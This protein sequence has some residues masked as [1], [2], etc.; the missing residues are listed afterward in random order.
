VKYQWAVA[1]YK[2]RKYGEA[3]EL[4]RGVVKSDPQKWRAWQLL[5]NCLFATK[6]RSG[7]VDAYRRSLDLHPDNRDLRDF[8]GK[9]GE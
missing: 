3:L 1:K 8:V 9:L 5:G 7:A 4:L 6:D 2:A